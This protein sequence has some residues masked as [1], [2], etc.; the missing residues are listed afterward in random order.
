MKAQYVTYQTESLSDEL[1]SKIKR[2]L[3]E[4]G[5]N[6]Q[7]SDNSWIVLADSDVQPILYNMY[8]TDSLFSQPC[9][10]LT[11]VFE[12]YYAL[13]EQLEKAKDLIVNYEKRLADS[14]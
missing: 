11:A 14:V 1:L 8:E 2:R 4:L 3:D 6:F 9:E 13:Q 7:L 10:D 12:E 5:Q